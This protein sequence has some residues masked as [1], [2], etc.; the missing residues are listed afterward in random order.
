MDREKAIA[1]FIYGE[2]KKGNIVPLGDMLK[3]KFSL[4]TTPKGSFTSTPFVI[5]VGKCLGKLTR[6][7]KWK[8]NRMYELWKSGDRDEKLIVIGFLWY[9]SKAYYEDVKNFVLR[10]A[11]DI[12]NWE[13]CDQL[14]L[15]VIVN[16]AI[17][18]RE[19]IFSLLDK[20][21]K[22]DNKWLRRLAIATIPPYIRTKKEDV[23]ICLKLLENVRDEKEKEV[24][25][26]IGWALREISK[27]EPEAVLKFLKRWKEEGVSERIIKAGAKKLPEE[28]K[29]ELGE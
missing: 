21:S 11:E 6:R 18:N 22:S 17:E 19:E 29:K 13:I 27:K 3:E 5:G 25:K 20:W 8:F 2:L 28:M 16:L 23:D 9:Y 10:I 24:T 1:T 12:D 4:P 26:A 7:D 14:A 15:K